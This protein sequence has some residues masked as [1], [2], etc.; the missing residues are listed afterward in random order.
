M[1]QLK[2]GFQGE[3]YSSLPD[4][5]LEKYSKDPLIKNLYIRKIGFFPRVKYHYI[6]KEKGCDYGMIIYC[7]A[8]KGWY[9]IEDQRYEIKENQF[10]IIPPYKAYSFGAS[11]DDPW[12]IYWLHFKGDLMR[13]FIPNQYA[14]GTIVPGDS[15]RVLDRLNLFEEIFKSFSMGYVKEYM[16]Y[17]SMCLYSL[18][19][20]FIYLEQYRLTNLPS[21]KEYS[22]SSKVIHYLEENIH[23]SI[24][25]EQISSYFKYSPSHF[26]TLFQ[27]ETGVSPI[28]Y[29]IRLKMQKACQ[30]LE[31]TNMKIGEIASLLDFDEPAYFS[32]IFTKTI[33]Q[34]PT[35]YRKREC[36]I[37]MKE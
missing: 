14:P 7:I 27:R 26:C 36:S 25:L 15:S 17:S 28:N 4:D 24:T 20:S 5:I 30:Y 13:H 37:N 34:S 16:I 21:P 12:T 19:A 29:F 9:R 31:L 33:G 2:E 35:Q 6:N 11:N 1:I 23:K 8:G 10:I 18:L 32:K 22:F 3:K